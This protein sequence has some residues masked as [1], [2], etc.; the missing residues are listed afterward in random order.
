MGVPVPQEGWEASKC[1]EAWVF[2]YPRPSAG[3]PLAMDQESLWV[4]QY[5]QGKC[6]EASS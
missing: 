2:Q 3:R 4:F 5:P 1:W 6:W